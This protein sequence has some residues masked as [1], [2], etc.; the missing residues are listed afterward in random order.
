MEISYTRGALDSKP[1]LGLAVNPLSV[2]CHFEGGIV[3]GLSQLVP[4][5]AIPLKKGKVEQPN[6][7]ACR[8]PFMG[9]AAQRAVTGSQTVIKGT[10]LTLHTSERATRQPRSAFSSSRCARSRSDSCAMVSSG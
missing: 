10:V 7:D 6:F 4:G 8:P 1:D 2:E 3:F 5:G 9:A